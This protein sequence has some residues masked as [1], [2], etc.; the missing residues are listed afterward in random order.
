ME[1]EIALVGCISNLQKRGASV[2]DDNGIAVLEEAL[3]Q[4]DHFLFLDDLWR[5]AVELG[6][7]NG[8]CLLYIR[9]I[10]L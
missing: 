1:F 3:E 2:C 10:I 6:D 8:S 4:F 9:I 5:D 7:G